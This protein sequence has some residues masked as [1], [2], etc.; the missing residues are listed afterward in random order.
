MHA[1][2]QVPEGLSLWSHQSLSLLQST[3]TFAWSLY[4]ASVATNSH[5]FRLQTLSQAQ[6]CHEGSGTS[7]CKQ[8]CNF[9]DRSVSQHLPIVFH[10]IYVAQALVS[11][12]NSYATQ[13]HGHREHENFMPWLILLWSQ[14]CWALLVLQLSC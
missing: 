11:A 3:V 5:N 1:Q 7:G 14:T 13:I 9:D 12:S 2:L 6:L 10:N 8:E 4:N